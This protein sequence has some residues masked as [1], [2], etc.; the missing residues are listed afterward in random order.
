MEDLKEKAQKLLLEYN[1]EEFHIRHAITVDE[2]LEW[3]A[4][5]Y[6]YDPI[7]WGVVGLLHDLDYELYPKEHCK[8]TAEILLI[9]NYPQ[10]FINSICSHGYGICTEVRPEHFM[11]KV[12]YSIDELSGIIFA[13]VLIRPS[14]STK[15]ITLSSLK[16]KFKDKAFAAKCSRIVIK[17]GANMLEWELDHLLEQ[18]LMAFQEKEN[19]IETRIK[20]LNKD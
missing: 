14:H 11:E 12:L 8:K 19:N 18:T 10:T 16:K 17:E 13:M 2:I 5:K 9:N 7:Y 1:K 20:N 3:F 6:N 4:H 15:D